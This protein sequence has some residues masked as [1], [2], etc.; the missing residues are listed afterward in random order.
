MILGVNSEN[1]FLLKLKTTRH[2]SSITCQNG[3]R[4]PEVEEPVSGAGS[5]LLELDFE[6]VAEP[7]ALLAQDLL[8]LVLKHGSFSKT[9]IAI[10]ASEAFVRQNA[11][12]FKR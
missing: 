12:E 10:G 2:R 5:V 9:A 11:S 1:I 3:A 4:E 8:N 7:K 6:E